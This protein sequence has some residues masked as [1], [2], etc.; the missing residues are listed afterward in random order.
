M[1]VV[2]FYSILIDSWSNTG[3]DTLQCA[4]CQ[5]VLVIY[6]SPKLPSGRIPKLTW[7]YRQRLVNG[8]DETCPFHGQAMIADNG[9]EH[10]L[11]QDDNHGQSPTVEVVVP[12]SMMHVLDPAVCKLLDHPYP[13]SL[14]YER[15]SQLRSVL[16]SMLQQQQQQ[17]QQQSSL[18]SLTGNG[19]DQEFSDLTNKAVEKILHYAATNSNKTSSLTKPPVDETVLN[20][21]LWALCGW[22]TMTVASLQQDI[23]NSSNHDAPDDENDHSVRCPLCGV[24]LHEHNSSST[25]HQSHGQSNKRPRAQP[26]H[27]LRSHKYYCPF[28]AG[29]DGQDT[30]GNITFRL[31]LWKILCLR[32]LATNN[33]SANVVTKPS[34][35]SPEKVLRALQR[36]SEAL[37]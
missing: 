7:T 15:G 26:H 22:T 2:T 11:N 6:Y 21:I 37:E 8:H 31:P 10:H 32:I 12:Q 24:E 30:D 29:F 23:T 16:S 18:T 9:E 14:L 19:Q 17:Q 34:L 1:H 3:V 27:P 33:D 5:K 25:E 35:T 4:H 20:S 13:E 36:L 28:V